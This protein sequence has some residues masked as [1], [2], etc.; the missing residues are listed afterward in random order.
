MSLFPL[1]LPLPLSVST[2]SV[3]LNSIT[4]YPF[5]HSRARHVVPVTIT[6]LELW[7]HARVTL[8]ERTRAQAESELQ[9]VS[10]RERRERGKK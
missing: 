2:V 6:G 9:A 1:S 10:S 5:S 4:R 8:P 3:A 7:T